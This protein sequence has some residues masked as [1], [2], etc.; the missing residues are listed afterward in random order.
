MR[1]E[2]QLKG[3]EPIALQ[4][5]SLGLPKPGPRINPP[6]TLYTKSPPFW[7]KKSDSHPNFNPMK[8]GE[9]VNLKIQLWE[10]IFL[11]KGVNL[12]VPAVSFGGICPTIKLWPRPCSTRLPDSKFKKNMFQ[13]IITFSGNICTSCFFNV[14]QNQKK[15]W[16]ILKIHNSPKLNWPAGGLNLYW[17]WMSMVCG[18]WVLGLAKDWFK[19]M[20]RWTNSC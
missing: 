9:N 2:W 3:N 19:K 18:L 10:M 14:E 20:A 12:Q 5:I 7:C 16:K 13:N 6:G 8:I 11:F 4:R 1:R 15:Q 17:P